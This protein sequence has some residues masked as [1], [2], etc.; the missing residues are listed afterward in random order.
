V[1]ET[2]SSAELGI[3]LARGTQA[4]NVRVLHLS[5]LGVLELSLGDKATAGPYLREMLDWIVSK[6]LALAAH[7]MAQ[8]ALEA[9][10][11]AGELEGGR[12][13]ID[14]FER[15]SRALDSA[16]GLAVA[17]RLQGLLTAAEGNLP[18][19]LAAVERS[20]RHHH[21][22]H[23]PF[24]GALTRLA[25][26]RIQRRATQK[27]AAG[28][29]LEQALSIFEGLPA[30]LWAERTR[31]ELKR[32]GRRHAVPGELTETE[33]RVAELAASGLRNREV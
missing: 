30:P 1:A 18:G 25:R 21:R 19:A 13:L 32:L 11:T 4:G 27:A 9:L 24:E 17:A 26:A 22:Q 16:W 33:R 28:Q 10:L 7:P 5:V 12:E 6:G 2:R 14:R 20:L 8:Y 31:E 3:S 23:W 29:S 15:E